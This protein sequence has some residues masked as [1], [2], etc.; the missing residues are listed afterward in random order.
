MNRK[1]D[2]NR[3]MVGQKVFIVDQQGD[4]EGRVTDIAGAEHFLVKNTSGQ[5]V[6]IHMYDVRSSS[7]KCLNKP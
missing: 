2:Y 1:E 3:K 5:E 6:K 7:V 4:W